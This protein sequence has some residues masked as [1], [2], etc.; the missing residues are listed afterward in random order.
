MGGEPYGQKWKK[1]IVWPRLTKADG[2]PVDYIKL[3]MG[4]GSGSGAQ[5]VQGTIGV[6]GTGGGSAG[7]G[8]VPT[9]GIIMWSGLVSDIPSG[10]AL[11]DGNDGT[12][13]LVD[14]FIV[15]VGG[16]YQP[17]D[18]GGSRDSVLVEHTHTV[19]D[20]GH[21]HI[22]NHRLDS[23]TSGNFQTLED[24]GN[25]DEGSWSTN[26]LDD[27]NIRSQSAT[28]GISNSTEGVSGSDTNLP[29]Y[30]ALAYIIKV[31]VT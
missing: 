26:G 18:Q 9:G 29:P 25:Q 20:P 22:I 3:N 2:G 31:T 4:S 23:S 27:G 11:C 8:N 5:G 6:Q 13:D 10:W 24:T 28:T 19:T 14:K 30:Y 1:Y 17:G 16:D 12:P 21:R 7:D 15:G